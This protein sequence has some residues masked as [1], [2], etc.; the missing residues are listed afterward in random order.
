MNIIKI[1][2]FSPSRIILGFMLA[3]AAISAFVSNTATAVMMLPI[4]LA[5]ITHA[6]DEGKKAGLD[7]EIDFTQGKF[8]FALN[9]MLGIS[10]AASIGGVATL[11]GTPPNAILSGYLA[12][13][14]NYS[15]SF[16]KWVIVGVPL[17]II[18]LPIAW[19][20]IL[21]T[22][23]MKLKKI[24]GGKDIIKKE[25]AE[26]G[27]M[28]KGEIYTLIVFSLTGLTWVFSTLLKKLVINSEIFADATIA[29][30]GGL[31]LFLIPIDLKK[32]IFVLDWPQARRLPWGV[33]L[34]F[35]GGLSLA[36]AFQTS[37]LAEWMGRQIELLHT[38]PLIILILI[39]VT[40]VKFITEMT[41]NTATAAL[42]MPILTSIA[43]GIGQDP[44]LLLVPS[45]FAVSCAFM[46]PVGTPPNAIVFGSGFVTIPQMA[47]TGLWLNIVTVLIALLAV[48]FLIIPV[49][50]INLN[51]IPLWVK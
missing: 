45:T 9:L 1:V 30:M 31:I 14:Y 46:L 11:I 24:P 35:G 4:G 50:D 19:I 27:K 12:T 7:K 38:A 42:M 15:I 6:I 40:L 26:M 20:V 51:S 39:A 44:L 21:K 8:N 5:V 34:L 3:T 22:N 2:G 13:T 17:V 29:M 43:I 41:S 32:N 47:K 10:Y 49:F 25:L 37:Q 33:L 18:M 48:Y 16:S 36:E 28:S 23:P